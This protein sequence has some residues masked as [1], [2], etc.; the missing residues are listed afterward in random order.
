MANETKWTPGP[1][2][3]E[4]T[5]RANGGDTSVMTGDGAYCIADLHESGGMARPYEE[6]VANARLVA[7]AP[8]MTEALREA[9]VC[10]EAAGW[11][12]LPRFDLALA[13]MR[14]ALS[15]AKGGE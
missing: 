7:A 14:A 9:I 8:D 3:V 12:T 2:V 10:A 4:S 6:C 11:Q 1:W 13:A 15:A 5:L